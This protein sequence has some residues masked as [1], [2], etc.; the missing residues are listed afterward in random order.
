M[1]TSGQYNIYKSRF[2]T[3]QKRHSRAVAEVCLRDETMRQFWQNVIKAIRTDSL[4][5]IDGEVFTSD[6]LGIYLGPYNIEVK[7]NYRWIDQKGGDSYMGIWEEYAELEER[8]EVISA[9]DE[10]Y[11]ESLPGLV[12]VLN[13]FYEKNKLRLY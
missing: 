10:D 4:G 1:E 2:I 11:D 3:G 9:R 13:G 12:A 8:F 5:E 7:H 6:N